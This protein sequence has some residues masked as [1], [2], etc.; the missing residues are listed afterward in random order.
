MGIKPNVWQIPMGVRDVLPEEA[1]R[2]RRLEERLAQLFSTWGYREV[3]PPCLEYYEQLKGTS[4]EEELF[5]LIETSGRILALRPD[6]T[7]PIARMAATHLREESLPLRLYYFGNAFRY[8]AIQSGRQRE[9]HQAGVELIGCQGTGADGEM[10][11][12][13]VEA[14]KRAGLTNFQLGIGQVALTHGLLADAGASP[15][16]IKEIKLLVAGKDFVSLEQ[17]LYQLGLSELRSGEIKA[18]LA[19]RGG[20]EV[21]DKARELVRTQELI[22]AVDNLEAVYQS[23]EALG[24]A[25]YVFFDFSI[26]RDFDYYT[27]LV[28][29]GYAAGLGHPICGGG[30]YDGLLGQFGWQVPAIG[31]AFGIDRLIRALPKEEIPSTDALI[32]GGSLPERFA[33]GAR[34]RAQGLKVEVDIMDLSPKEAQA[35]IDQQGITQIISVEEAEGNVP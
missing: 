16:L 9:F 18:I 2:R 4:A 25:Q 23:L 20:L 26:L 31:F 35:Y 30:R 14:L 27:G 32:I 33:E 29:E 1:E 28:F 12:L 7:T 17:K 19:L 8:E 11:L 6:L 34:L 5:K 13:A 3:I 10:I 22:Q 24:L 15:E 21:L